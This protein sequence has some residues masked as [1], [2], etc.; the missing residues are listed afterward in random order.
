MAAFP[1]Q[2]AK[3]KNAQWHAVGSFFDD[4][5]IQWGNMF[6]PIAEAYLEPS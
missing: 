6:L 4:K 3:H 1:S 5:Y 2:N